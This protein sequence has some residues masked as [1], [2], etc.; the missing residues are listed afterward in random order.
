MIS[1]SVEAGQD[2]ESNID[3]ESSIISS[4]TMCARFSFDIQRKPRNVARHRLPMPR[5]W[6]CKT[7]TS[8]AGDLQDSNWAVPVVP[9]RSIR[10]TEQIQSFR[11]SE[12]SVHRRRGLGQRPKFKGTRPQ[13]ACGRT[14]GTHHLTEDDPPHHP[15]RITAWGRE[16]IA[17][18]GKLSERH[19]T[20]WLVSAEPI[21]G[22]A[23]PQGSIGGGGG[24]V[25][26]TAKERATE[27][28]K[29]DPELEEDRPAFPRA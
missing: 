22:Q 12:L 6:N 13:E 10:P 1:S 21:T 29:R 28:K 24:G 2:H 14:P 19:T 15:P 16:A 20:I 4:R 3:G 26:R 5:V 7:N 23:A 18:P 8:S 27:I 9:T 25:A 17:A 11:G